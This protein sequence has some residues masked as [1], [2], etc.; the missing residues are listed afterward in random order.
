M[1]GADAEQ[2][3]GTEGGRNHGTHGSPKPARSSRN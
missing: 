3:D 1:C 2:K